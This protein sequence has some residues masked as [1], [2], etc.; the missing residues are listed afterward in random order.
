MKKVFFIIAMILY[1]ISYCQAT[2]SEFK[3]D[4]LNT[5]HVM[6][7]AEQDTKTLAN[8]LKTTPENICTCMQEQV[9][10][11]IDKSKIEQRLVNGDLSEE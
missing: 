5:F 11:L 6:C 10:V 3:S 4:F 1:S 2:E 7:M 8:Q 9:S